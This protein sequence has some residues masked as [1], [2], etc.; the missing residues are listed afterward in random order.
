MKKTILFL[1]AILP[2]IGFAQSIKVDKIDEFTKHHVIE[3]SWF[4]IK[5]NFGKEYKCKL[6]KIDSDKITLVLKMVT[7]G[8]MVYS[9]NAGDELMLK[10]DNDSIV[11]LHCLE[12]VISSMSHSGSITSTFSQQRYSLYYNDIKQILEHKVF[13]FRVYTSE[14]YIEIDILNEDNQ[15]KLSNAIKLFSLNDYNN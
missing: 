5:S 9:I 7:T 13:K 3:S 12:Y 1:I 8:S 11:T 10:L 4:T 14:G 15:I 6:S 2:L